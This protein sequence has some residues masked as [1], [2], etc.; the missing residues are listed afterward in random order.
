M[1]IAVVYHTGLQ[2]SRR[3]PSFPHGSVHERREF[4]YTQ[5][6]GQGYGNLFVQ[7]K[8]TCQYGPLR[9]RPEKDDL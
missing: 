9:K 2:V 6:Q 5:R 1:R 4:I 3:A 8:S 7:L